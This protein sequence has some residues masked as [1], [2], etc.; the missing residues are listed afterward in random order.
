MVQG[1][2]CHALS[3]F[4]HRRFPREIEEMKANFYYYYFSCKKDVFGTLVYTLEGSFKFA[5]SVCFYKSC[6]HYDVT[7]ALFL[8]N[9]KFPTL[10]MLQEYFGIITSTPCSP[11]A[12]WMHHSCFHL[13]H[14]GSLILIDDWYDS[15]KWFYKALDN[16]LKLENPSLNWISASLSSPLHTSHCDSKSTSF[17]TKAHREGKHATWRPGLLKVLKPHV[18]NSRWSP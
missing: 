5:I 4:Q 8:H 12:N 14:W 15:N 2:S 17:A 10:C 3:P 11:N 9:V 7:R 18:S 1:G 16:F 13:P 6:R